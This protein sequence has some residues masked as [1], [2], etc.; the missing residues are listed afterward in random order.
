VLNSQGKLSIPKHN[1]FY[2]TQ[3]KLLE[4]E[5]VLVKNGRVDLTE[6]AWKPDIIE[7]MFSL[8]F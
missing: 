2:E 3:W 8:S 1:P 5:G 4:K 6:F 7:L